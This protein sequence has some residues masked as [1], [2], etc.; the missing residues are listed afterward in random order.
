MHHESAMMNV[1]CRR[2]TCVW[3]LAVVAGWPQSPSA[4]QS[5]EA[6]TNEHR[7]YWVFLTTGKATTGVDAAEIQKMQSQHLA[8]FSRL[9]E[10]GKLLAAGPI[11]PMSDRQRPLRGIVVLS[12]SDADQ[13]P[14]MFEPDPYIQRGYMNVEACPM[15]VVMGQFHKEFEEGLDELWLVIGQANALA[16]LDSVPPANSN[17]DYYQ[18]ALKDSLRLAVELNDQHSPRREVL[19]LDKLDD[20]TINGLVAEIPTNKS[21]HRRYQILPLFVG[22]GILR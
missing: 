13:I 20:E 2:L 15:T 6:Q 11:G 22:R 5:D 9:H 10:Q 1:R 17:H 8:N 7:L 3:V 12:A 19:V 14:K 18:T 4:A 21:N 16:P